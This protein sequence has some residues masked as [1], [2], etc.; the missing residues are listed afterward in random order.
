M[1]EY[2]EYCIKNMK[3]FYI[4]CGG[5]LL[6]LLTHIT[7]FA[8]SCSASV[9]S[10]TVLWSSQ[11][12]NM[13]RI[14]LFLCFL[15]VSTPFLQA[16]CTSC[17]ITISSNSSSSQTLNGSN[18]RICITGGTYTGSITLNGSGNRICIGSSAV[19]GTGATF[20]LNGSNIV[21][22]NYGS[23]TIANLS[24]NTN[25]TYN[26]HG[27][28]NITGA[29]NLNGNPS[30]YNQIAGTTTLTNGFNVNTNAVL[31]VSGGMFRQ[32]NTSATSNNNSLGTINV[33]NYA[34]L[35][36]AGNFTN[37]ATVNVQQGTV[38]VGGNFT[39]NSGANFNLNNGL[40]Q[41][42]G[43]ATNNGTIQTNGAG[44]SKMQISGSLTNNGSGVINGT[45]GAN[46]D[47]C[48]SGSIT[49][50]GSV[51][52][53]QTACSCSVTLP[54]LLLSFQ[55]EYKPSQKAINITWVAT[56]DAE[57]ELFVVQKSFDG[58]Q[59]EDFVKQDARLSTT[60][61]TYTV[62]DNTIQTESRYI[63]YRLKMLE[64]GGKTS[65]SPIIAINIEQD[66]QINVFPNP[67]QD[68]IFWIRPHTSTK[69]ASLKVYDV[70]GKLILQQRFDSFQDAV[71]KIDLTGQ[72]NGIYMLVWQDQYSTQR[73]KI[74]F[75][76]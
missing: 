39:N 71:V 6:L 20:I 48:V 63:Y 59:F 43:S 35:D 68:G 25:G 57:G 65:Y 21:V 26:N 5:L 55:G 16:Q 30:R 44:C 54:L 50:F 7:S 4:V 64:K 3:F 1:I 58:G 45:S 27:T 62:T 74:A 17:N 11:N 47:V 33:S 32:T 61:V 8:Q 69:Q 31:N 70:V 18:Q 73:K 56:S 46:I 24:L 66:F 52:N 51:G 42:Y 67:S 53:Q 75:A 29:L 40:L 9:G 49:N 37:N 10:G 23:V 72:S 38:K 12:K 41:V 22:D 34:T 76:K 2:A 14:L 60:P 36:L 15:G 28:T 19:V 13:K